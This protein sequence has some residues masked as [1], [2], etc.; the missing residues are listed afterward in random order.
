MKLE[1]LVD[2]S[3]RGKFSQAVSERLIRLYDF[4]SLQALRLKNAIETDLVKKG[5]A[6]DL[7]SLDFVE[8]LNCN[9]IFRL[10][11]ENKGAIADDNSNFYCYLTIES[12]KNMLSLIAPFCNGADGYQWLYEVDCAVDLLFSPGGTW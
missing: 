12:Y 3:D 6:V 9:L 11:D 7:A 2:I 4:D 5:N 8:P 1:F 10:S